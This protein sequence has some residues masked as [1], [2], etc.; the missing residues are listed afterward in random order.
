MASKIQERIYAQ[1][2]LKSNSITHKSLEDADPPDFYLTLDDDTRVALEV[3]NLF[4]ERKPGRKGSKAKKSESN[5]TRW[6]QKL[7]DA[8]Y[9]DNSVPI[10]VLIHLLGPISHECATDNIL[11]ALS[12]C[13]D[14]AVWEYKELPDIPVDSGKVKLT[15]ER[16]PDSFQQYKRWCCPN[17]NMGYVGPVTEAHIENAV[18]AKEPKISAYRACCDEVWLL[19]VLDHL[20]QSG[21]LRCT[22][23]RPCIRKSGFDAIWLLEHP[24]TVHRVL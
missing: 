10:M 13:D 20:W 22:D 17:D 18:N 4:R 16:L 14:I 11:T 23:L 9:R 21:M 12:N 3:T 6:L 1:W 2:F 7:A 15:I 8:Y 5:R 19:L 24:K